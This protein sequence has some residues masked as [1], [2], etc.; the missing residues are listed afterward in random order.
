VKKC[1]FILVV[2]SGE[3]TE[4]EEVS[5]WVGIGSLVGEVMDLVEYEQD[6]RAFFTGSGIQRGFFTMSSRMGAMNPHTMFRNCQTIQTCFINQ[7]E[8]GP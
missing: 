8:I 1:W 4:G 5:N 3:T 7:C 6:T 2:W